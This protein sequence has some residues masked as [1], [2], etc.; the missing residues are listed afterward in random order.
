MKLR[1]FA[2]S[3]LL[4]LAAGSPLRAEL[5]GQNPTGVSGQFNGNVTTAGSYDPFTGNATRAITDIVVPGAVGEYGLSFSRF[6]NS[7]L[8]EYQFPWR[9]GWRY[10]YDW[11]IRPD[12]GAAR[13]GNTVI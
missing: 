11:S 8:T 4:C 5:G 2:L 3:I 9:G 10:S 7:R 12:N 1:S 13:S 6:W